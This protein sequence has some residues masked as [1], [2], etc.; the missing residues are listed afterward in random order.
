MPPGGHT[1]YSQPDYG[2]AIKEGRRKVLL[3]SRE[4][5]KNVDDVGIDSMPPGRFVT[6][7][8]QAS[9][10]EVTV[11]GI[12]IPWSRSRVRRSG[13]K[14]KMWE[15]HEQYLAGLADVLQH[16]RAK[17]LIV[18]GDFNQRIGQG[19]GVPT[20][21]RTA[22]Q[23]AIPPRM[24]IATSAL[25]FQGRRSIDHIALSEDLTAES[26]GVISNIDGE[27]KLSDHFGVVAGLVS[28]EARACGPEAER[29]VS[30]E[31]LLYQRRRWLMTPSSPSPQPSPAKGRGSKRP[32]S[33]EGTSDPRTGWDE[34]AQKLCDAGEDGLLD[35]PV[36]SE[37][38]DSEW[39]WGE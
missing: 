14:R 17:R 8:T 1:I 15:D 23:R 7:V 25:G 19:G 27:S 38:D 28:P 39:V 34:A 4:P 37:F 18:V 10:G 35:E 5:W 31:P 3:W 32:P 21:L 2:H 13:E 26:L 20:K 16:T 29:R 9:A 22:L 6:G 30:F 12:C 33:L 36:L 24:T 11:V